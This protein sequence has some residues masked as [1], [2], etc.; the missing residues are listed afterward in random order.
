MHFKDEVP[1]A[2]TQI[3]S[4]TEPAV[5]GWDFPIPSGLPGISFGSFGSPSASL[6][7]LPSKTGVEIWG[8]PDPAPTGLLIGQNDQSKSKMDSKV[9]ASIGKQYASQGKTVII[10]NE[11]WKAK[12]L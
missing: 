11:L 9:N 4:N 12:C 1:A 3:P 6:S 2:A 10:M 5:T 8:T 7:S